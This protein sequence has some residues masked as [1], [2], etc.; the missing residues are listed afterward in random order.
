MDRNRDSDQRQKYLKE[1]P[2]LIEDKLESF[3]AVWPVYHKHKKK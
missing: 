1:N 2:D 3:K